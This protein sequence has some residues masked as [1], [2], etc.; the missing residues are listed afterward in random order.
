MQFVPTDTIRYKTDSLDISECSDTSAVILLIRQKCEDISSEM[1]G[2]NAMIRLS[3]TGRTALNSELNRGENLNDLVKDSKEYF[4]GR[5]PWIWIEK[6][7]LKTAGAYDLNK[8]RQGDDFAADIISICD[9]LESSDD[10][11]LKE[12]QEELEPLFAVWKGQKHLEELA[13][14]ELLEILGEARDSILNK[15]V[16][17]E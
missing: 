1:D 4:E 6:L 12:I 7:T 5:N 17:S 2:R 10:E 16:G 14:T 15:I 8:L 11:H 13:Q 9:E 3:L